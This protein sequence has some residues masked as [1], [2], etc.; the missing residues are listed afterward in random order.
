MRKAR[1]LGVLSALLAVAPLA[2]ASEREPR[3]RGPLCAVVEVRSDQAPRAWY[4]FRAT[5]IL[6]LELETVVLGR[7]KDAR[8]PQLR[9]YTP[10]GFLYQVLETSPRPHRGSPRRFE[11]RLPVAGT[12]IMQSGLYGR[13]RVV[14]YLDNGREPCGP[15]RSFVI[16]P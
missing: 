8:A 6:A 7:R 9:V 1:L 11:A 4:R 2:A 14:P 15:A 5:R 16:R 3:E 13:W 12:S 10:D